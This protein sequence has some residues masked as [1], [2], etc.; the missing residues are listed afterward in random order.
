MQKG[1]GPPRR[2]PIKAI[3]IK[4]DKHGVPRLKEVYDSG[5][6]PSDEDNLQE[7]QSKFG[8]PVDP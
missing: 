6:E 7:Y 4:K 3:T 8:L 5:N 1:R 2:H